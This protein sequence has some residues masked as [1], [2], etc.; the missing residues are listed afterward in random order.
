MANESNDDFT[1]EEL[2]EFAEVSNEEKT[3]LERFMR[4][5]GQ[6]EKSAAPASPPPN[7]SFLEAPELTLKQLRALTADPESRS[8]LK[9]LLASADESLKNAEETAKKGAKAV[10]EKTGRILKLI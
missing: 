9:S 4:W 1:A 7:Q 2:K 6:K 3:K 10:A 8:I 5:R